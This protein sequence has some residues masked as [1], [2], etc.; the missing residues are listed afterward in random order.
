VTSIF[1]RFGPFEVV[2]EI[3]R[4]GM[5]LVLLATDTRSGHHVALKLVPEGTDREGREILDAEEWGATLQQQFSRISAHVPA[6]YE[7]GRESGYFYVAM[8]YL[9]GENL[10]DVISRGPLEIDRA[11]GI[12]AD[13]CEFLEAAHRFEPTI[14]DRRLRSLVHGDLKPR[15]VRITADQTVKVLDFGIAKA[16]SLSRKVTRND[17]GTMPYLS[18]ERLE[19]G[20]VDEYADLWAVGVMLYEM[21]GGS[22]P[23]Q[24][25]DTRRLEQLIRSRRPAP[26]LSQ[27]CPIGLESIVAKLLASDPIERYAGAHAIR[28]DL[29][30]FRAGTSTRAE[31]EGWPNRAVDE[32]PTRRT[33]APA[34]HDDER[35]QRTRKPDDVPP[36]LPRQEPAS[37][38]SQHATATAP[39]APKPRLARPRR[40]LRAALLVVAFAIVTNELWVAGAAGRIADAASL[41]EL[42]QLAAAW[43]EYHNL[44]HR[45]YLGIGTRVLERS[46]T[47]R[48]SMLAD[49]VIANYRTPFPTVREAQWQQARDALAHAIA[50]GAREDR[51]QAMLRYCEG[52]LHRINGEASK[53]RQQPEQAR[54]ELTDA[55]LAFREAAELRPGWP[56][57]FLGLARTFIYGLDDVDRGADALR[58]AQEYG[59]TPSE[60][61]IAQLADGYRTR[62]AAL[63]RTARQ[64]SGMPQEQDY[65]TRAAEAFRQALT[66]YSR[67]G[68]FAGVPA[69]TRIVQ[70]ALDRVDERLEEL[71]QEANVPEAA[72]ESDSVDGAVVPLPSTNLLR[73]QVAVLWA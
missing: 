62:G 55:V 4:G 26:S 20:D 15:N 38:P 33:H 39:P 72:P 63:V 2:R 18:P 10:S 49:R 11:A 69:N 59:H 41:R 60:R 12:A 29:E 6:V 51:V 73:R 25:P 31:E 42:D 57:P 50:A 64:L 1:N 46:L 68:S 21:V 65:L 8:E 23:F 24:A 5:A 70:R 52:H 67:A 56:D 37:V 53:A 22:T 66:F 43:D 14:A 9:D 16:L 28:E 35:T 40:M 3:G 30:R 32:Q 47:Q 58:Q 34:L 7:H 13:L 27:R 61:E 17:F 36:V 71:A 54:R 19:S 44:A 45:S 48:T